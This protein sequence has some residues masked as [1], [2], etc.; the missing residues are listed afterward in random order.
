MKHAM[1]IWFQEIKN[2]AENCRGSRPLPGRNRLSWPQILQLQIIKGSLL[3]WIN[4]LPSP[5][6]PGSNEQGAQEI[7][8]V[9]TSNC[10]GLVAAEEITLEK[11]IPLVFLY[12]DEW[13][14]FSRLFP[15]TEYRYHAHIWSH[16]LEELDHETKKI[17]TRYPLNDKEKYWL[18]IEGIM[19]GQRLGRGIEHLWSWNGSQT[20]LLKKSLFHWAS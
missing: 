7:C 17:A 3:S 6:A 16:F 18:H 15:D 11:N 13:G 2:H 14:H 20:K 4:N 19:R 8:I 5:G 10:P 1:E 12:P 9:F